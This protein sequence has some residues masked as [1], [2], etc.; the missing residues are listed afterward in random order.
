MPKTNLKSLIGKLNTTCRSAL[1]AAA[2]L[3]LSQTH[4]E[5]D[6]EHF[7]V[8]LLEMPNTDAQR[9]LRH[10]EINEGRVVA[11]LARAMEAFQSG[12]A[13]TPALSPRIPKMIREAWLVASVEYASPTIRSGHALLALM[14]NEETARMLIGSSDGLRKISVE[15]L[16]ND[17]P[18]IVSGSREDAESGKVQANYD[19]GVLKIVL[20]KMEAAKPKQIQVQ[21]R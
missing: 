10:F 5:V 13:R 17:L 21:V 12:N 2:G 6:L 20:P 4:Y 8:K 11:D 14:A 1:E 18:A 9:I 7:L 15:A 16:G 19:N 3:C